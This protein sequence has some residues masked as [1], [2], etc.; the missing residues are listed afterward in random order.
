MKIHVGAYAAIEGLDET[1]ETALY[2][3]LA[4][5]GVAGL[6]LPFFG[7]A[8]HRRDN[9]WMIAQIRPDWTLVLT[10]LFGTMNKL[11][12]DLHFGL[13]SADPDGR[14]RALDYMEAA[15]GC[16]ESIHHALGR[17]AVR[18]VLV[19][20]APRLGGSGAKS[21]VDRFAD[22]LSELR[23][24]DWHGAQLLVEHCDS[25]VPG[26]APDKGFL[27]MEDDVLATK[28]SSGTTPIGLAVNWGRSAVETRSA[29]GPLEHIA[30]ANQA[31]LLGALFFSGVTPSHPEYGE[32]RDSHAPFSTTCPESLLTPAAAKAAMAAAP[33]CPIL[34]LKLQT[35]PTALSVAARLSIIKDGYAIMNS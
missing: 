9:D 31:G 29:A 18:A 2:A 23:S 32:W 20:S 26:R 13:A 15:R 4:E 11:K 25:P 10:T 30:R 17:R 8:V 33:A 24:R 27:R 1:A 21:S 3:G 22:S 6:E 7:D 12:E 16:I 34:G 28:L 19:H 14:S 5:M 35:K